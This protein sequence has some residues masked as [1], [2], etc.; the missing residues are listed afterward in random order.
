MHSIQ[1]ELELIPDLTVPGTAW[2][3]FDSKVTVA[4]LTIELVS[5]SQSAEAVSRDAG[6]PTAVAVARAAAGPLA[7]AIG[8]GLV[9]F[10]HQHPVFKLVLSWCR[11]SGGPELFSGLYLGPRPVLWC[12]DGAVTGGLVLQPEVF[13][14]LYQMLWPE[15][16]T[17]VTTVANP[18]LLAYPATTQHVSPQCTRVFQSAIV[19]YN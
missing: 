10:P 11:V 6:R 9:L 15:I 18:N 19:A 3:G 17:S 8:G 14:D 4:T 16:M 1:L 5:I 13:P 2:R 12:V 7:G